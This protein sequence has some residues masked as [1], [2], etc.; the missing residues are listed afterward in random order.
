VANPSVAITRYD[1]RTGK[2]MTPGGQLFQ[3]SNLVAG[4]APKSWKDMLPR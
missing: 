2:Y 4:A 1:P 3:Q